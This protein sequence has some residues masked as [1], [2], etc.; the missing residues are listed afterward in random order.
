[1]VL[2][3][4]KRWGGPVSIAIFLEGM[5]APHLAQ[6]MVEQARRQ[7]G[8]T[9]VSVDGANA[10]VY[11]INVLRNM[12][13]AR[14]TTSHFFLTDIDLWPS[15]DSYHRVLELGPEYLRRPRTALLFPAFEYTLGDLLK[16]GVSGD[17]H[18]YLVAHV[19]ASFEQ[20]R[21]CVRRVRADHCR[22]FKSSTD[23]HATTDYEKWWPATEL[24]SIPCFLSMRYE[25][26]L[27]VPHR[28]STPTFDERF[29]GYGARRPRARDRRDRP[30]RDA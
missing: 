28:T 24:Y 18:S 12:A 19:P 3:L 30:A 9:I 29:V 10:S 25:P 27:V 1:M 13:V 7:P 26:Y 2:P 5:L 4:S 16:Q 8:V 23:T 15:V 21:R 6:E 14:V 20:L 11:P 17:D 22:T